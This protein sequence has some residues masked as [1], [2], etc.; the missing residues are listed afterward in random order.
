MARMLPMRSTAA[1][2]VTYKKNEITDTR[3]TY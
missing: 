3:Y 2:Y 1:T